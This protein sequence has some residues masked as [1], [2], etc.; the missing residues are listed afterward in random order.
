MEVSAAVALAMTA[1]FDGLLLMDRYHQEPFHRLGMNSRA[2]AVLR[3]MMFCEFWSHRYQTTK[4][5]QFMA[6]HDKQLQT[7]AQE[8]LLLTCIRTSTVET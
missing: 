2:T 6:A 5:L 7:F 3:K 1:S 8:R 4:R